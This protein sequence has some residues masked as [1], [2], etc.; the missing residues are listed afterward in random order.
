[1]AAI[2]IHAQMRVESRVTR[3]IR[4]QFL[5]EA[6]GF[7][8]SFQVAERLR[9]QPQMQFSARAFAQQSDVFNA[10]PKIRPRHSNLVF[11]AN[12]LLERNWHGAD[13]AFDAGG[14]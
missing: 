8:R 11:V 10:T 3:T 13:A 5:E 1:M 9:L 14:Q 7:F 2:V 4:T 12:E 6:N